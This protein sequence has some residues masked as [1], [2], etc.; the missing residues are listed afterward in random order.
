MNEL[1]PSEVA[2]LVLGYL[3]STKCTATR[4]KFLEECSHLREYVY[5]LENGQE[6]TTTIFGKNLVH[7]LNIGYQ[8]TQYIGNSL[9]FENFLSQ[10]KYSIF[11]LRNWNYA[12]GSWC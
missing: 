9:G 5:L 4:G 11:I 10:D 12:N 6:Y 3:G 8:Y 1:L 2:R 7:Y